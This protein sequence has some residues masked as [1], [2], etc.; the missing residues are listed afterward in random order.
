[1]KGKMPF[2]SVVIPNY[3]HARY[4]DQRIQSVLNQTYTRFEVIILDDCSSDNSREIIAQYENDVH[5][6]HIV[7]NEVNSGS[8]FKQWAKGISLA[9]GE[10][11]WIAES[12]DYCE[13]NLLEELISAYSKNE[14]TV[15][16]YSTTKVVDENGNVLENGYVGKNQYFKG[17]QFAKRYL[18]LE[19]FIKNASCAVFR[20]EDALSI[21][22]NYQNYL[23]AG[24]YLFWTELALRGNVAIV[25]KNLSCFR[26]HSGVVT[27]KRGS[28]G[29]NMCEEKM[30][31]DY[32][33]SKIKIS[34]IRMMGINCYHW[35]R[36]LSQQFDNDS[37]RQEIE[38]LWLV[39]QKYTCMEFLVNKVEGRYR[40]KYHHF[41]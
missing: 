9:K 17:E 28:D 15:I 22:S 4:L 36:I 33:C 5:V 25:N 27:S 1:M 38:N 24:D 12:D 23:G 29:T 26:R 11:I 32:I 41:L 7:F 21:P 8:V 10:L 40:G 18:T 31:L 2:V 6:S 30:I 20:K 13:A 35:E 14:N 19:N 16:A 34:R 3:N 37:I 39:P